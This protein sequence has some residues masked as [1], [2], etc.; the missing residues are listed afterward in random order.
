MCACVCVHGHETDARTTKARDVKRTHGLA[1][2]TAGQIKYAIYYAPLTTS[3][4]TYQLKEACYNFYD[5]PLWTQ[6][7]RAYRA[8]RWLWIYL[9]FWGGYKNKRINNAEHQR[10]EELGRVPGWHLHCVVL[11][12]P[13]KLSVVKMKETAAAA[14]SWR[15]FPSDLRCMHAPLSSSYATPSC[16]SVKQVYICRWTYF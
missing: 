6:E 12:K 7:S 5:L 16:F 4:T 10:W 11:R 2:Q 9:F 1:T 14:D 15:A 3:N 8:R 13:L